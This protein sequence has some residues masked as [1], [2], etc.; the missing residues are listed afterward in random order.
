MTT[1]TFQHSLIA[2]RL[3]AS[4]VRGHV[5]SWR[6]DKEH[7]SPAGTIIHR[8]GIGW[9][10][11]VGEGRAEVCIPHTLVMATE[12]ALRGERLNAEDMYRLK[13]A[14]F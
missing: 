13:V 4:A 8:Q 3:S 1:A 2:Q 11:G 10:I 6:E 7:S 12:K 9:R 14:P 5:P